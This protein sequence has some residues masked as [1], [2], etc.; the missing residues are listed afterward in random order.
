MNYLIVLFP[1]LT[2]LLPASAP[3][4]VPIEKEPRHRL[5]FSNQYVR[6][7]HVLIPS[8]DTSLFHTH[9]NEKALAFGGKGIALH[10]Y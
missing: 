7:F 10:D 3:S 1:S 9:V 5:T 6:L 8:G 2:L 4:P